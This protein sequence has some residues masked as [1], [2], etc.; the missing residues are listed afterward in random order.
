MSKG[1][2]ARSLGQWG[3]VFGKAVLSELYR[4][5]AGSKGWS[6]LSKNGLTIFFLS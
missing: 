6:D 5:N 1:A 2:R 4:N 3:G